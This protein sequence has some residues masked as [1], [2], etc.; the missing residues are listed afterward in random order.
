MTWFFYAVVKKDLYNIHIN[1]YD[2]VYQVQLVDKHLYCH[3]RKYC[4]ILVSG[5]YYS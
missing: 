5:A 4:Q 2:S 3:I 1:I